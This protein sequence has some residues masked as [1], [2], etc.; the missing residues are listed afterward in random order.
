MSRLSI[1]LYL[2]YLF[3]V[4]NGY[5]QKIDTISSDTPSVTPHMACFQLNFFFS[6]FSFE[7]WMWQTH[8]RNVYLPPQSSIF[9]AKPVLVPCFLTIFSITSNYGGSEISSKSFKF[10]NK[11]SCRDVA[12]WNVYNSGRHL[13]ANGSKVIDILMRSFYG[14]EI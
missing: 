11:L 2:N 10:T 14:I 8:E 5:K 9:I 7:R 3:A 1:I 13:S 12:K 4:R 6:S